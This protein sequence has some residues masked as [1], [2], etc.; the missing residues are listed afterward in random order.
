MA[1]GVA[2]IPLLRTGFQEGWVA[3]LRVYQEF[4]EGWVV[5]SQ[6]KLQ[7]HLT[8]TVQLSI[9][10][11]SFLWL[12]PGLKGLREGRELEGPCDPEAQGASGASLQRGLA[13]T[14]AMEK[15]WRWPG[16]PAVPCWPPQVLHRR[17]HSAS[18]TSSRPRS[19]DYNPTLN[20]VERLG[21]A[22]S[23]SWLRDSVGIWRVLNALEERYSILLWE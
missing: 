21:S 2:I 20:A 18:P 4:L 19:E 15:G 12:A 23:S 3:C 1:R 14:P 10:L 5:S 9:A 8:K 17:C 22:V 13:P 7:L 11:N 6:V 16:S